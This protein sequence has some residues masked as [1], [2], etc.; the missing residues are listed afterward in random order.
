MIQE[1]NWNGTKFLTE[2][3]ENPIFFREFKVESNLEI[4]ANLLLLKVALLE[5]DIFQNIQY[6]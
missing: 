5:S 6:E 4:M 3:F 1:N 2:K